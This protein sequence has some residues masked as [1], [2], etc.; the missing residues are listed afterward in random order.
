MRAN[1][2]LV[3]VVVLVGLMLFGCNLPSNRS[4]VSPITSPTMYIMTL[5]ALQTKAV[6]TATAQGVAAG[7]LPTGAAPIPRSGGAAETSL[8]G[9]TPANGT[10]IIND[11]L[12]WQGP[13]PRYE[14]TSAIFKGTLVQVLG[15]SL[16]PGWYIVLNP[17]YHNA[18]WVQA[19]DV[20]L[21]PTID[22]NALR[23]YSMPN[24][25][26]PTARPSRTPILPTF[27]PPPA[28]PTSTPPAPP[29]GATPTP[30]T[31]VDTPVP[32]STPAPPPTNTP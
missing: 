29:P 18:C 11:T 17:V 13:G 28:G 31:V 24:A 32:S 25:S 21:D 27:T 4:N 19:S 20:Q 7:P 8:P 16:T 14:T 22:V 12:C 10:V 1:H 26:T 9:G 5:S 30:T 15:R 6:M 23:V 2:R 3:I